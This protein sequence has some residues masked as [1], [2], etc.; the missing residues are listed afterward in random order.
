MFDAAFLDE[1]VEAGLDESR[2]LCLDRFHWCGYVDGDNSCR[3][4]HLG[5]LEGDYAATAAYVQDPHW[6]SGEVGVDGL[7]ARHGSKSIVVNVEAGVLLR[8]AALA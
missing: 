5:E 3:R 2:I 7:A 6:W 4:V 1:L 8:A